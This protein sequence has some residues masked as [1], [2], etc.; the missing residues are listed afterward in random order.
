MRTK[1][2]FRLLTALVVALFFAA[3]SSSSNGD[4]PDPDPQTNTSLTLKSSTDIVLSDNAASEQTVSFDASAYWKASSSD[5]WCTV[6]PS[7][8]VAATKS[9]TIS[10]SENTTTAERKATVTIQLVSDQT[11][12]VTVNVTQPGKKDTPTEIDQ[13]LALVQATTKEAKAV[14]DYLKSIYGQKTLT[15]T[16]ANV[17]WNTN[18]ADLVYK[19]TGKYPAI[20]TFDYIHLAYSPTNWI[21]YTNTK[22]AEDWWNAGGIV[23]ACWHWRVPASESDTKIDDYTYEPAKT[24]FRAKNIFIDGTWEKK[25]ADADLEKMADM[26]LLLQNKGIPV[27]W[28]PLHEAAGSTYEYNNGTAWFWWGYDGA[29]TYVKLWRYMFDFFA[30]KGVKNLIWVWT[31][32]TKDSAFYPGDDYVDIIGRDLY[33]DNNKTYAT[34][35]GDAEQF[36]LIKSTYSKKMIAL[37]ECGSV[38]KI[39][40]QWQAG[41]KWLYVM[42]WYQYDAKTLDGHEHADTA[43]WK[44]AMSQS[45]VVTRDQLP[46]FK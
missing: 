31:T 25:T 20:A 18:E 8:G 23:S 36:S 44:D 46:S 3:C 26:L 28:R 4:E 33:G 30:K 12:A 13:N 15:A 32:Q 19:A 6:N 5:T 1:K 21:D 38:A 43:W 14:Y 27:I 2:V 17:N 9:L 37:S 41:A 11:K 10:I 35:A 34:A 42:P 39:S 16:M 24:T 40:E 45:N 22:V 7:Q 29:E